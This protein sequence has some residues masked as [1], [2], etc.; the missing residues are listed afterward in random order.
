MVR[1]QQ[2]GSASVSTQIATVRSVGGTNSDKR[3]TCVGILY[4]FSDR[5]KFLQVSGSKL[6]RGPTLLI[7]HPKYQ[8]NY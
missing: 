4:I 6:V 5:R 8:L 1:E 2:T 7:L 3:Q